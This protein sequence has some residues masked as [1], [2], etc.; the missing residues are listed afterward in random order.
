MRAVWGGIEMTP[1]EKQTI[2]NMSHYE[3]CSRWRFGGA[4]DT[5]FQG[6]TGVYFSKVLKEKGGFTS[7]ISKRLG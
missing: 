5:L 2:D 3:L 4:G 7:E 6:D 1:E